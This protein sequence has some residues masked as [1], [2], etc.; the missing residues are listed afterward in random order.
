MRD[1]EATCFSFPWSYEQCLGALRQD[2]FAAYGLW[3]AE[4]LIAYISCYRFQDEMEIANF[5]VIPAE[6]RK[7]F[8]NLMLRLLL[9]TA[10]DMGMRKVTLETRE[11]NFPAIRLYEKHGFEPLG[12]RRGYY[13]DTNENALILCKSL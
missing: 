13:P 11:S 4:S 2:A 5:A 10:R 9:Q 3:R 7:G 8:G 6:R 1:L 12:H